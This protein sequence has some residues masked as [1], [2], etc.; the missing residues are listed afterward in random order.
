M[1][2]RNQQ[3]RALRL[4]IALNVGLILLTL[5]QF[6]RSTPSDQLTD[7]V[8]IP[9]AGSN[10]GKALAQTTRAAAF[11]DLAVAAEKV[12]PAV[13]S[14]GAIQTVVQR[15]WMRDYFSQFIVPFDRREQQR[16]PY[17]GSGIIVTRDGLVITNHHVVEGAKDLFV[18]MQ[19][20]REVQ[21]R[22]V[23]ADKIL[24]IAVLQLE[25]KDCVPA[26]IGD[27]SSLREG[28]WV[29][30][31]GNPFGNLISDPHATV[32]VGVVSA[33]NRSFSPEQGNQ[34]VYSNMIQTDA[35][36]NPGNSGGALVDA[37]G[38]VVG[39]NTFIF[40]QSGGSNGIGFAI[41]INRAMRVL[42]EIR[43]HGRIR[44]L[45]PDFE[46]SNIS[47]RLAHDLNLSS[48]AGVVVTSVESDGAATEA[49]LKPG[50]LILAVNGQP[51][52]S[53]NWFWTLYAAH[54]P[55]DRIEFTIKRAGKTL[56]IEYVISAPPKEDN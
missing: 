9:L 4:L 14:I 44:N 29:L 35:A 2:H 33:L 16:I 39:I 19:D 38:R 11:P 8:T 50:D 51:C 40:T 26:Q 12:S 36:I 7:L 48:L 27:S 28:E 55:G 56:Q 25:S 54:Y 6:F 1:T 47:R 23:D 32:T 49:G 30:A 15:T 22:L 46:V 31:V 24:D 3:T 13:V 17:I 52:I 10:N 43:D 41:P 20:G 42:Q 53:F 21:A 18:T 5:T 37:Q 34:R 45:Y